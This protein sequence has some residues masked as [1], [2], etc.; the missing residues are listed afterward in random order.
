MIVIVDEVETCG[1][2]WC[3]RQQSGHTVAKNFRFELRTWCRR[4]HAIKPTHI[5]IYIFTHTQPWKGM[6]RVRE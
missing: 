3:I 6:S 1:G 4:H 5:Y 2:G